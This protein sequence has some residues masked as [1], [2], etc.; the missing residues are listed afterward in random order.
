MAS[1]LIHEEL[2]FS[3][4][5]FL[6]AGCSPVS[7]GDLRL[8]PATQSH[9]FQSVWLYW[10]VI[11]TDWSAQRQLIGD[12]TNL[13]RPLSLSSMRVEQESSKQSSIEVPRR[14]RQSSDHG[15]LIC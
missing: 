7:D 4:R 14:N 12:Y 15:D 8:L 10:F 6:A 5:P 9:L 3:S 2:C 13:A 11:A 1:S